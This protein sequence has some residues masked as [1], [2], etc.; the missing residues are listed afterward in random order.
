MS[1]PI[2]LDMVLAEFD[3]DRAFFTEVLNEFLFLLPDQF[4][5][6]ENA[7]IPKRIK[8]LKRTP[9]PSRA[10]QPTFGPKI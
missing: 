2:D 5:I 3:H 4:Q 8:S 9:M 10:A 7:T 1:P 6:M